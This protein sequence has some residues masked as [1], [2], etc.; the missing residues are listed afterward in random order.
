MSEHSDTVALLPNGGWD[1]RVL[2][3]GCGELV[4][5]FVVVTER[6][7]VLVDTL[8]N[9]RTAAA[10][11]EIARPHLAGRQLLAVDT[12]AD[13]DHAW[14]NGL[15]AGPRAAYPAPLSGCARRR[16]GAGWR[17]CAPSSRAAST[18]CS[19]RRRRSRSTSGWRSTAAT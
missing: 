2:A 14:G 1:A 3:C 7:V 16:R 13:W 5:T 19:T 4:N 6:Y 18:T 15:F 12:H 17:R 11:L 9:D 10:L 8:I